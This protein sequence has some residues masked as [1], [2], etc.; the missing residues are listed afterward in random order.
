MIEED[1]AKLIASQADLAAKLE[2]N[3]AA[4]NK[5]GPSMIAIA[6]AGG[7]LASEPAAE[8][9]KAA[10]KATPAKA[11]PAKAAAAPKE[12]TEKSAKS[13]YSPTE[14]EALTKA[15]IAKHPDKEDAATAR[16]D[17][18]TLISGIIGVPAADVKLAAVL[19]A[20]DKHNSL[21]D[22]LTEAIE[23]FESEVAED[24]GF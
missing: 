21:G 24:D 22:A 7:E 10:A 5:Y 23:A 19:I 15:Y 3:T 9:P 16:N 18:K 13:K 11:T 14:I 1:I 2:A 4:L 12:A 8:A 20:V 6:A 17:M